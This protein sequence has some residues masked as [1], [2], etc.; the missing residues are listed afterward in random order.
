[1]KEH[2]L[3]AAK[4]A[5]LLDRLQYA[6]LVVGGHDADQNRLGSKGFVEPVEID[7][8]VVL[9][10]KIR[11]F[12]PKLLQMLAR[13]E[14]SLVLGDGGN[15]VVAPV[16]AALGD[17][18]KRQVVALGRSR[19][20]CNLLGRGANQARDLPAGG[21]DRFFGVPAELVAV[22]GCIAKLV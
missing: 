6:G 2:A 20:K 22:A 19:S 21:L 15:E 18:F 9:N 12:A 13:I 8:A 5:D 11:H 17:S 7:E 3:L 14:H 4:L 10:R 16:A 1:M